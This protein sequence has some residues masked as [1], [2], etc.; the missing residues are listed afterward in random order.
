MRVV[1]SLAGAALA[2]VMV[3]C[4]V[5]S[6][7][8]QVMLVIGG[9]PSADNATS[10]AMEIFKAEVESRTHDAVV[11]ELAPDMKLG[12]AVE[13]VQKVRAGT[14]FGSWVPASYI[15]RLIPELDVVNLPFMFNSYDSVQTLVRGPTGR[16]IESRLDAKGFTTLL[17]MEYGGRS[18]MNA[19]RPLKTLDDFKDLKLRL[20]PLEILHA[21][22][23]ALGTTTVTTDT[24]D[25][26]AGLQRGDFDGM[27]TPY[28]VSNNFG[29]ADNQKY[30]SDTNHI[31]D[32]V[33]VIVNKAAFNHLLPEQQKAIRDAARVVAP[34]ERKLVH[35]TEAAALASLQARGLQFDPLPPETRRAIRKVA[36]SV[37]NRMKHRIDAELVDKVMA[38]VGRDSAMRYR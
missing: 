22:Y 6:Q 28:S 36:A 30:L 15:S 13:T 4:A 34:Q 1:R 27:E 16:L 21:T 11:I 19:K 23:R 35:D 20:A 26:Y 32:P 31:Q 18:V 7:A 12:G 29:F 14:V 9:A 10:R 24:H 38:E 25:V 17:W 5:P 33:L 2:A 8:Q 37:I 3:A